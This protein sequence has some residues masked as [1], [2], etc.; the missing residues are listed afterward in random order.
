MNVLQECFHTEAPIPKNLPALIV[1]FY[2]IGCIAAKM[3]V[4]LTVY[5]I[6][7]NIIHVR[8]LRAKE[9]KS[10]TQEQTHK[11]KIK[12]SGYLPDI[13]WHLEDSDCWISQPIF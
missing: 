7:T 9:L 3:V 11:L 6:P 8:N 2:I 13:L 5:S 1:L 4:A 10:F 12:D